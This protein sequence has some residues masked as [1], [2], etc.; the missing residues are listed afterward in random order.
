MNEVATISQ[1]VLHC[2]IFVIAL[3]RLWIEFR[4]LIS[5][6]I[7]GQVSF[8]LDL[9]FECAVPSGVPSCYP[10]VITIFLPHLCPHHGN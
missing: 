5:C 9:Q 2:S 7:T 8:P 1:S 10:S 4:S 6:P 3:E